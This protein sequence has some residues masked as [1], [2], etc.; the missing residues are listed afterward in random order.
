MRS[1]GDMCQAAHTA[2]INDRATT[3]IAHHTDDCAAVNAIV[4][5]D[6][7]SIVNGIVNGIDCC[8]CDGTT[9]G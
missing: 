5:T 9:V 6:V 1:D 7:G 2:T 3:H 4:A 8:R